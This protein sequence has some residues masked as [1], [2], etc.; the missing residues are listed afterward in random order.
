MQDT[1]TS[2]SS[3]PTARKKLS[4]TNAKALNTMRQRL[5]KHNLQYQEQIDGFRESPES[6][7]EESEDEESDA[8]S[9]VSESGADEEGA[10]DEDGF[11]RIKSKMEK[12]K[13]KLLTMDP[14]EITYE[15]VQR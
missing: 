11:E 15:M 7:E 4:P 2:T 3:N 12:R 13:D 10:G 9:T 8:E 6:P 5:K 1:V 14:T